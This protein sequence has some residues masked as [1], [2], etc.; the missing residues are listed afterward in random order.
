VAFV[1]GSQDRQPLGVQPESTGS[2]LLGDV[3]H[4]HEI[5][6]WQAFVERQKTRLCAILVVYQSGKLDVQVG[7]KP[8]SRAQRVQQL[9]CGGTAQ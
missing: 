2:G 4:L 8:V 9:L 5:S 6:M 7:C 3:H 1:I